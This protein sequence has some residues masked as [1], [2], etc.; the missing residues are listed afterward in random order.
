MRRKYITKRILQV[1]PVALGVIVAIFLLLHSMPGDFTSALLGPEAS[2]E[3]VER[4][5]EQY[6]LNENIFVQL[7]AYM[8]QLFT[9]D[10]GDSI[11]FKTPVINM[12][13]SAFPATLELAIM[14]MLWAIIIAVPLGIISAVKQ[15][16]WFDNFSMVLAQLGISMPVFWMGLLMI[17]LF[18]VKLNWLPS[19]GR[20]MPLLQAIALGF[21]TGNFSQFVGSFK[22]ILMP[23]FALGIMSAAMISRMIRST[24]LEVLD[25]DYIRTA[26]AKG[27]KE[28]KVVM[29]HAFRNALPPVVTIVALQFGALLGGSIVTETV[30]SWPGI[31]QVVVTA[32][33]NR[34]YPVVQATIFIIAI[35]FVIINLIVD[36][37][38]AVINPKIS[39]G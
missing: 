2:I 20:G 28:F 18:S 13:K 3:D 17:L 7:G 31:G 38:Y 36:L 24:M 22:K 9:L 25:M 12:I 14:G 32:I 8:K 15:N 21:K 10:F 27:T 16:S 1:I 4:I 11:I 29:K 19:F 30:F 23:S 6:G 26:R 5:R 34:D 39:E 35:L 37:L 33:L